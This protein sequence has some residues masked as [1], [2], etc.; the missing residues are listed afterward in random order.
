MRRCQLVNFIDG[1]NGMDFVEG[2]D[3]S[4]KESKGSAY[5]SGGMPGPGR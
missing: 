3:K 4:H 5:Y 1:T 2:T